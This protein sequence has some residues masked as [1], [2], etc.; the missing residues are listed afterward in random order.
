MSCL[1][2]LTKRVGSDYIT[3]MNIKKLTQAEYNQLS[4]N[5]RPTCTITGETLTHEQFKSYGRFKC[6]LYKTLMQK[7]R[8]AQKVRDVLTA[9]YLFCDLNGQHY[10]DFRACQIGLTRARYSEKDIEEFYNRAILPGSKCRF[11]SCCS[12]VP[13]EFFCYGT[14]SITHYNQN[15]KVRKGK[16]HLNQLQFTCALDGKKFK[17]I[18]SVSNHLRKNY[19]YT[20]TQMEAYYI[21]YVLKSSAT[22]GECKQCKAKLKFISLAIGYRSFCYNTDCNVRWYNENTNRLKVSAAGIKK[23]HSRGDVVPSQ[24]KFWTKKGLTLEEAKQARNEWRGDNSIPGIMKRFSCS[25]KEATAIRQSLTK[26][27]LDNFPRMNWSKASQELFWEVYN[28]VNKD[29]SDCRF[30]TNNNGIIDETVNREEKI[31]TSKAFVLLDFW[32]PKANAVIEFDGTYWHGPKFSGIRPTSENRDL[33]ILTA[34]PK[35]RILHVAEKD[36]YNNRE[37]T[38]KTCV[39]FIYGY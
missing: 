12:K 26:K 9:D 17:K 25:E 32:C 33:N 31:K 5:I 16:M 37:L 19:K 10:S 4:E 14:C 35:S 18:E 21:Q 8:D 11:P 38:I 20:D 6:A 39:D 3:P 30:A 36:F 15:N 34:L 28:I 1:R 2:H 23:S 24:I 29:F 22:N 27:W 7:H 13:F